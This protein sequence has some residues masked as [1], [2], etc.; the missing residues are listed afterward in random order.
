M[1]FMQISMELNEA[2][3]TLRRIYLRSPERH[4]D[5]PCQEEEVRGLMALAFTKDP[6]ETGGDADS[7]GR[8][9]DALIQEQTFIPPDMDISFVRHMRYMPAFWHR[10]TFFELLCVLNGECRNIFHDTELNMRKGD[11]C[12]HAPGTVHAVSA[13]SDDALLINILLRKSTFE[14]AFFSMMNGSSILAGFF[15]RSFY[16]INEMPYLLFHTGEDTLLSDLIL[17]AKAEAASAHRYKR[18]M[19]NVLISQ[20]FV[21]ML[22]YHE[23]SIEIPEFHLYGKHTNLMEILDYI[24][25]NYAS[26][27]LKELSARFNYSERQLQRIIMDAT[28]ISFRENIQNQKMQRAAALLC[29]SNLSVASICEQTGYPSQNNF[30]KIFQRFYGMT[31]SEYRKQYGQENPQ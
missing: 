30:R 25:V 17:Q 21:R 7:K 11:I 3:Q 29:G 31:P 27:T 22:E 13:F 26:I 18:H 20:M 10:H 12:I 19:V 5:S 28:G 8:R 15:R 1:E 14:Q 16:R 24:N 9:L 23:H 2:E 6:L 4:V